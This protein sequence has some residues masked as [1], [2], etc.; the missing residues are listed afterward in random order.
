MTELRR[1]DGTASSQ[2]ERARFYLGTR[3]NQYIVQRL[4]RY[5]KS[6]RADPGRPE[7]R[8]SCSL[9][10]YRC[11]RIRIRKSPLKCIEAVISLISLIVRGV[12]YLDLSVCHH[13]YYLD[14]IPIG[15][16]V[17]VSL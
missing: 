6:L 10:R 13:Y 17:L 2:S 12:H 1:V 3:S 16:P 5:S 15:M 4:S 9:Y 14:L 7:D 8:Q 11:P